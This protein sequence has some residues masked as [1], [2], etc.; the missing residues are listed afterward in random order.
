MH[1]SLSKSIDKPE[2]ENQCIIIDLRS[3]ALLNNLTGM[4]VIFI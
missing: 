3:G 1:L 2:N 4:V